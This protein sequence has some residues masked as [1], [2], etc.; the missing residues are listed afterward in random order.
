MSRDQISY[1]KLEN[2]K[3]VK[4]EMFSQYRSHRRNSTTKRN[5]ALLVKQQSV[6]LFHSFAIRIA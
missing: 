2:L 6:F 4:G 1:Q 5:Y 3:R